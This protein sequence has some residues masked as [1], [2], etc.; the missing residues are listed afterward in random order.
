MRSDEQ[1]AERV[2]EE[3][4]AAGLAARQAEVTEAVAEGGT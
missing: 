4:H 1:L 2:D 3:R